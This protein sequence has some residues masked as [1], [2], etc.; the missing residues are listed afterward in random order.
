MTL[1]FLRGEV[2]D[3]GCG[4]G[5]L[6]FEAAARGCQVTA[7]DG[8]AAAIEHVHARAAAEGAAVSARLADL[9]SHALTGDYDCVVCIG[10]LMFFDC[11][12]AMRVLSALQARVRPGGVAAINVLIEGT[13][14][15]EMFDPSGHCLFTREMLERCFAGWRL[16][17]VEVSEFEAPHDTL[18]R[19][20]TLIA[21]KGGSMPANSQLIRGL[22]EA[23][24]RGDVASV[25]G[26]FS[27]GIVWHEAEGFPHGGTYHGP[28]AIVKNIFMTL[29]AE[30]DPFELA[31]HQFVAEGDT[32]VVMG[33]YSGKYRATGKRFSAPFAHCWK[34]RDG[35][36]VEF[37]Q[38]TDTVLVQR[39]LS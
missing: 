27:P 10:L 8:S 12:T 1:P 32:V 2:L 21:R 35:K 28:D 20:L 37:R 5:N 24:T 34:V 18:K 39:A 36:V 14:Y 19:F 23:F 30:W 33:Q 13:T 22:Y 9:R 26:A 6:C 16:E 7:L 15:L 4:M 31:P 17:R 25:L 38:Y 29:G 11:P 3:L